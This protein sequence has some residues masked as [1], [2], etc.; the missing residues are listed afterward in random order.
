M[1]QRLDEEMVHI[2]CAHF[3]RYGGG[4]NQR[5]AALWRVADSGNKRILMDAF[6][7]L[8]LRAYNQARR[9]TA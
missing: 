8:F 4:F 2:A 3:D 6:H 7:D 9:E 5:L 1:R